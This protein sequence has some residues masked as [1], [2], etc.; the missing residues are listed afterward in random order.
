MF[1]G[2][3]TYNFFNQKKCYADK[4]ICIAT[5]CNALPEATLVIS[6]FNT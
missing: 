2:I 6:F 1:I 5:R 4:K 3:I